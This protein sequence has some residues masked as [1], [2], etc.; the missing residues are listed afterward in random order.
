MTADEL[1]DLLIRSL[2]WTT[3]KSLFDYLGISTS[4]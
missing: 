2:D 4:H 3:S 1:D